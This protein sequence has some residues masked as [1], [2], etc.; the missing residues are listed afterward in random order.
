MMAAEERTQ[1][2]KDYL[3]LLAEFESEL[4]GKSKEVWAAHAEFQRR[5]A[6]ITARCRHTKESVLRRGHCDFCGKE[7]EVWN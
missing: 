2:W 3:A 1:E 7:Q 4:L 5:K 6:E